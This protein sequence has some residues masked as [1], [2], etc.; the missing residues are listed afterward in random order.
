MSG[1]RAVGAVSW[2]RNATLLSSTLVSLVAL[3]LLLV[4]VTVADVE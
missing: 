3:L 4:R 1:A 2:V